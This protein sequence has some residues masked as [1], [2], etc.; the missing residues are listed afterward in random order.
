MEDKENRC[1]FA[2]SDIHTEFYSSAKDIFDSIKWSTASH[3]VLAGDIGVIV[4]HVNIYKEFLIMCKKKYK[5]IVLIPGN[6][7][8]YHCT[9]NRTQIEQTIKDICDEI[10]INYIHGKNVVIDGIRFIGHT[11][12]SIIESN[13]CSQIADFSHG[14]FNS[15][16]EY[17]GA[18]IDGFNF[19]QSEIYKSMDC[20][21]PIVI[22][23]H[24][25]P[26]KKLIHP[27]FSKYGSLNSAFATDVLS[28]LVGIQIVKYWFCGHT[29]E[30]ADMQIYNTQII[31]NPY[32]YPSEQSTRMTKTT[33]NIFPI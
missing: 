32:G 31:V 5:N 18:F 7:E 23:T 10:G 16:I 20:S 9:G 19:I 25:L 15:Q 6:H 14:V 11:L 22:V 4:T 17:V 28:T 1:I 2:I 13:A 27:K 26:S 29:H 24:H 8:Y 33:T 30:F 3:L 12:W 21:E